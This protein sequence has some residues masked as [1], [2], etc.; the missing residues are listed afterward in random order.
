[1]IEKKK[2]LKIIIILV[3]SILDYIQKQLAF[4]YTKYFINNPWLFDIVFLTLF[5]YK[6][7]GLKLYSHQY[8]ISSI[9]I[10]FGIVLNAIHAEYNVS[11]IYKLLLTIFDEMCFNLGIVL[12][13]Y[14]I[15][16]SINEILYI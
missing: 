16:C 2:R 13:K 9:M 11:L 10:I 5:S 4:T 1:M 7:L 8:I 14:S 12:A 3:C 6:I 15:N